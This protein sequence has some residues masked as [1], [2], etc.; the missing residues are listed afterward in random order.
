MAFF[1]TSHFFLVWFAHFDRL[2]A[3]L[4]AFAEVFIDD[5]VAKLSPV[6][7]NFHSGV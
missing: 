3:E 1:I 5:Y 4:L 6:V 2:D 7:G